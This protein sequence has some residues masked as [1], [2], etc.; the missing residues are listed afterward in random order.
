[1]LTATGQSCSSGS[2]QPLKRIRDIDANPGFEVCLG[3]FDITEV[4]NLTLFE[5]YSASDV[6]YRAV[7]AATF[8]QRFW[9]VPGTGQSDG[10]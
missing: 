1:M 7:V 10:T 9:S 4:D 8:A 6:I 3:P 2:S 5:R